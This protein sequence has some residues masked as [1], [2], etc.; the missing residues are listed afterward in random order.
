[1][2][3]KSVSIPVGMVIKKFYCHKCGERLRKHPQTRIVKPGDPDYRKH[4]RI[5]RRIQMIGAVE[6]T[7]YNFR[8]P[9]CE[10]F[11]EYRAQCVVRKMQKKLRKNIL[12][13][14]ELFNH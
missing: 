3:N 6:V 7:E 14:E 5:N 1:M 9:A 12:T 11:M 4:S 8:C 2:K 13:D 10:N